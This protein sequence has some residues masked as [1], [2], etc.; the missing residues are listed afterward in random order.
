MVWH[1]NPGMGKRFFSSPEP[2]DRLW[3]PLGLLFNGYCSSILGV[4]EPGHEVSHW[5][6][7]SAEAENEWS[8][9]PSTPICRHGVEGE[10]FFFN[11]LS[12]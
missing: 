5:P 9:T 6:H 3:G 10:D 12:L 2:P 7:S 4:K 1:S 8:C 11:I